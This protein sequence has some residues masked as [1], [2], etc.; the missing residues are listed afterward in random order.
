MPTRT[1]GQRVGWPVCEEGDTS[2]APPKGEAES[3]RWP[4]GGA[5][6]QSPPSTMMRCRSSVVRRG[7]LMMPGRYELTCRG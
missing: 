6:L 3:W 4:S 1:V 2:K 7:A 5:T